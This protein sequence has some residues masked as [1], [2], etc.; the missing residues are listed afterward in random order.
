MLPDDFCLT[1]SGWLRWRKNRDSQSSRIRR[2]VAIHC[3]KDRSAVSGRATLGFGKNRRREALCAEWERTI[4]SIKEWLARWAIDYQ[5]KRKHAWHQNGLQR[6]NCARHEALPFLRWIEPPACVP[7][8][9][10]CIFQSVRKVFMCMSTC[11]LRTTGVVATCWINR[12]KSDHNQS[13][14][15]EC[16]I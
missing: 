4:Q 1:G 15:M 3:R 6:D 7:L 2:E 13:K 10:G 16:S 14:K 11:I 8:V 12:G 5:A 9:E